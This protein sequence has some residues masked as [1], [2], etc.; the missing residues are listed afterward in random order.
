MADVMNR[1]VHADVDAPTITVVPFPKFF[2]TAIRQIQ[3]CKKK[4]GMFTQQFLDD[5]NHIRK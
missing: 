5:K 4:N 2:A 3:Y 1:T